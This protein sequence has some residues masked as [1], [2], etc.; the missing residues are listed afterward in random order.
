[1]N[2]PYVEELISRR[3]ELAE[4]ESEIE[5]ICDMLI[6][7]YRNGGKVLT[8]GNGGSC[9]DAGH[10]VG[11]LMKGYLKQ[12]PLSMELKDTLTRFGGKEMADKL[13]TPL[14]AIDLTSMSALITAIANDID[15]D[16]VYAQQVIG[17][18]D[19]GD[20]FIGISTSGNSKN[21][22]FAAIA[23]KA[24]GVGLIGM[25]GSNGGIMY[26]SGL[27]DVVVRVPESATYRIQ[28]EHIAIYHAMCATIEEY[29]YSEIVDVQEPLQPRRRT[30]RRHWR[31]VNA[32]WRVWK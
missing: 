13:Q 1:M 20:V 15:A 2:F 30:G 24:A 3:P 22:H 21:V 23:A 10:I 28:E 12:R 6:Y 17:L 25:T 31:R 11:E 4:S 5:K 14:R 16:Y 18:A 19:A 7:T 32:P 27:Y 9:S 8:C 26:D 29:Y